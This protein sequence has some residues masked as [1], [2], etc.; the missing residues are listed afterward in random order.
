MM[1]KPPPCLLW[2]VDRYAGAAARSLPRTFSLCGYK[3]YAGVTRARGAATLLAHRQQ[4]CVYLVAVHAP[5]PILTYHRRFNSLPWLVQRSCSIHLYQ[6]FFAKEKGRKEEKGKTGCFSFC[7]LFLLSCFC[8]S[9]MWA[10]FHL[11][12]TSSCSRALCMVLQH[13]KAWC[14]LLGSS[15]NMWRGSFSPLDLNKWALQC[16]PYI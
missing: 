4:P 6:F 11:A 8:L 10:A 13:E 5:P 12:S 7:C 1:N 9:S 3:S 14:A 15:P 2:T 16:L